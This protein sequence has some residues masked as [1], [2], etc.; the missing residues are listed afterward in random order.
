M[1]NSFI[2][3]GDQGKMGEAGPA[4]EPG[5]P[6]CIWL[7][8]VDEHLRHGHV[9]LIKLEQLTKHALYYSDTEVNA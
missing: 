7:A 8:F 6:V 5:I 1:S 4:G 3:Q 2:T 9:E